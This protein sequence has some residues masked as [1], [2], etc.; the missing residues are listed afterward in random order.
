MLLFLSLLASFAKADTPPKRIAWK[1]DPIAIQLSVNNERRITFPDSKVV[2]ADI[3]DS[4]KS[5]LTTQIVN[6]DVYWLAKGSFKTT[7][8]TIGEEGSNKVYLFDVSASYAKTNNQRVLVLDG[9][10][11]YGTHKK[12]VPVAKKKPASLSNDNDKKDSKPKRPTQG[13][14]SLIRFAATELYAPERLRI[15]TT[16]IGRTGVNNKPVYHLLRHE[17]ANTKPLAAWRSG[18]LFVTAIEV[19]NHTSHTIILDPR[20]I[21][22]KWKAAAFQ[23]GKLAEKGSLTDSTTL[24]LV[25]D[26]PFQ[27]AIQ[28]N[29][30]ITFGTKP[31]ARR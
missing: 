24:Y 11:P 16:S 20:N 17:I 14:A 25:S 9:H 18:K 26:K 4:L 23:H 27:R 30:V 1:G 2:W 10:D 6:N 28:S 3:K 8:L 13:Y 22:G 7:R 21:R 5:K 29:P 19:T 15:K 31:K 12:I